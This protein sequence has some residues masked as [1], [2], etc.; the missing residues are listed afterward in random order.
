MY[1]SVF[2]VEP[3]V[4]SLLFVLAT[5]YVWKHG[6][7][8]PVPVKMLFFVSRCL[9]DNDLPIYL[10]FMFNFFCPQANVLNVAA[11]LSVS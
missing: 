10:L 4:D 8:S 7:F 6:R 9:Y 11:W 1:L 5:V 2:Q 3:E